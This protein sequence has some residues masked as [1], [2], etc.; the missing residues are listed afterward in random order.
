MTPLDA[1]IGAAIAGWVCA[2]MAGWRLRYECRQ[3]RQASEMIDR[4]F[5]DLFTERDFNDIAKSEATA[6]KSRVAYL[7]QAAATDDKRVCQMLGQA[8]GYPWLCDDLVNFPLA[9]ENDGVF[10]G[11]HV[12]VTIAAEAAKAIG[13]FRADLASERASLHIAADTVARQTAELQAALGERDALAHRLAPFERVKGDRG[14]FVG[15]A[16]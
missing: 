10:V 6:L 14:R 2:G 7:E 3:R 16:A 11:E 13:T 8:L 9:T 4:L 15:R 12:A 5:D 1:L